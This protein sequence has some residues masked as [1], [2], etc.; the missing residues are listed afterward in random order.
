MGPDSGL[1]VQVKVFA[2]IEVKVLKTSSCSVFAAC[3]LKLS[4]SGFWISGLGDLGGDVDVDAE[5][6]E[7]VD[8]A[9]VEGVK[10]LH[11]RQPSD[12][13]NKR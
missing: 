4:G 9:V 7:V 11:I 8:T 13:S 6:H 2:P 1:C 5:V 3:G 10:A 12:L